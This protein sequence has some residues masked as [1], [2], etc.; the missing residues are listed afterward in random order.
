MPLPVRLMLLTVAAFWALLVRLICAVLAPVVV[1]VK[2]RVR[3]QVP[4]AAMLVQP[5]WPLRVKLV[6]LVPVNV[7]ALTVRVAVPVLLM[8]TVRL[9]L[10]LLMI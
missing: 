6:A 9:P 8:V 7:M 5:L 10:A 4:E 2:L 1:G 3:L